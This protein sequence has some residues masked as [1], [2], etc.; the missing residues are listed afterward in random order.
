VGGEP[1]R[2]SPFAQAYAAPPHDY[3]ED[4]ILK[5]VPRDA[6]LERLCVMTIQAMAVVLGFGG[7]LALVKLF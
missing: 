2:T 7:L 4:L 3:S 5:A 1:P 6:M